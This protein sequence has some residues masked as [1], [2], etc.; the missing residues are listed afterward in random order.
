MRNPRFNTAW[1]A[2]HVDQI[3]AL[4]GSGRRHLRPSVDMLQILQQHVASVAVEPAMT[5]SDE[6]LRAE[7]SDRLLRLLDR[8][9]CWL[10]SASAEGLLSDCSDADIAE[11]E[12]AWL[13]METELSSAD[14]QT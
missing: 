1:P 11:A 12:E 8:A 14:T 5:S 9:L 6:A 13:C 4:P 2:M 3:L 7:A 10:T